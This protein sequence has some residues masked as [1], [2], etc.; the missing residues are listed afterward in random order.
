MA[1][2]NETSKQNKNLPQTK[3]RTVGTANREQAWNG[4]QAQDYLVVLYLSHEGWYFRGLPGSL[5][6]K[7]YSELGTWNCA[8]L[9]CLIPHSDLSRTKS[10]YPMIWYFFFLRGCLLLFLS[11]SQWLQSSTGE[12]TSRL[13]NEKIHCDKKKAISLWWCLL[14]Y[15]EH[16]DS[17]KL[18]YQIKHGRWRMPSI[19]KSPHF[20]VWW[21]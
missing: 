8:D 7:L 14:S 20:G 6:Q 13:D 18:W 3:V 11:P 9:I 17:L 15:F 2:P 4:E 5:A 19:K 12:H 1:Q 10:P 16:N 21:K